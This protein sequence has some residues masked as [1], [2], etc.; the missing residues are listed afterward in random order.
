MKSHLHSQI[1]QASGMQWKTL[2]KGWKLR[3]EIC[4]AKVA[5]F[6]QTKKNNISQEWVDFLK[7]VHFQ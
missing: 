2:T 5:F 1:T 3:E 4:H 7:R 6:G